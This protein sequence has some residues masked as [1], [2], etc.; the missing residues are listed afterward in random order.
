MNHSELSELKRKLHSS[1]LDQV[2]QRLEESAARI[3]EAKESLHAETK[4]SAGDKHET[5]IEMARQ[6]LDK[7]EINHAQLARAA[8]QL[9]RLTPNQSHSKVQLGSLVQTNTA[10]YYISV[11]LGQV[12]LKGQKVFCISAQAPVAAALLGL[13]AGN[14]SS[15]NDQ[16]IEILDVS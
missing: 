2:H 15:F 8:V 12:E 1:C 16:L 4:G 3:A 11:S 7:V 5:A 13:E 10:L 6:E 14:R 9:E